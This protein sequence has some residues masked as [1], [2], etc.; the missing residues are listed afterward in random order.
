M[1]EQK[2]IEKLNTKEI[3]TIYLLHD[4]SSYDLSVIAENKIVEWLGEA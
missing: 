1:D 3:D 2:G 4:M